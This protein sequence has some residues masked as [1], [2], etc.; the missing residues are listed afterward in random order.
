MLA[1]SIPPVRVTA[2]PR[3]WAR[4]TVQQRSPSGFASF[5]TSRKGRC[6]EFISAAPFPLHFNAVMDDKAFIKVKYVPVHILLKSYPVSSITAIRY[7]QYA[8]GL[9]EVPRH[10]DG[11]TQAGACETKLPDSHQGEENSLFVV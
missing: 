5:S 4:P 9:Q 1:V 2:F 7:S 6:F 10:T 3:F 11:S 8:N